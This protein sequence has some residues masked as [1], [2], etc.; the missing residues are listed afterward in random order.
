[1]N[2]NY[3]N[4]ARENRKLKAFLADI[5]MTAKDFS[6][7]IGCDNRY[8]SRVMN[9]HAKPGKRLSKDV[10]DLTDGKVRLLEHKYKATDIARKYRKNKCINQQIRSGQ[11]G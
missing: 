8:L 3:L 1:M 11:L 9:G 2:E 6:K 7:L 4:E 5:D 10:E